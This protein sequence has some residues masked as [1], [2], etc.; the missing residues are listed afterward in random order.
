MFGRKQN[1]PQEKIPPEAQRKGALRRVLALKIGLLMFFCVVALRLIQIQVI[2]AQKYK[3]IARRQ[4]ESEVPLPA[5]RGTVQDRHG[6]VLASN[7]MFVSFAADPKMLGASAQTVARRFARAFN[8]STEHYLRLLRVPGRRFVWLERGADP[9]KEALIRPKD[10]TGLIR[11]DEPKRIYHYEHVAG[12]L[13]GF[14]DV[15]NKGLSGVELQFDDHLRGKSGNVV[16]QRDGLGRSHPSVDYPRVEPVSGKSIVLTLDL[17][18]QQIAE[19]ELKR[20]IERA[21]AESGL[22]VMLDPRTGEVLAMANN[23]SLNPNSFSSANATAMKNRVITDMFEPGSVFKIVTVSAALE[24]ELIKKGEKFF[25]EN[26]KYVVK[27]ARGNSRTITDTHEHG[28]LSFQEAV[29]VSSNIVMAKVSDRIG[30]EVLYTTARDFGFGISTGLGLS[31]EVNG[32]LKKPTQW[33]G[34][35][36]NSIAYGYEV[37]ATPLQIAAAYAA[38]ANNGVLMKPFIVGKILDEHD[39]VESETRPQVIRTVISSETAQQLT[40]LLKG[41]VERGT[42]MTAKVEGL[43]VAGKTGT[44]RKVIDGRYEPGKY[45]ASFAGF[46][47]AEDP[48]VVCVVMLDNPREGYTGALASAPIFKAIAAK[49]STTSGRFARTPDVVI[50]G[51]IPVAVPDVSN[52]KTAVATEILESHGFEVNLEGSGDV[53]YKQQPIPGTKIRRKEIVKLV[54]SDV[55]AVKKGYAVVPDLRGLTIRR[56]INKLVIHHLDVNIEGSGVV[57]MQTPK[58]GQLVKIGTKVSLRCDARRAVVASIQ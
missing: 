51:Q 35:T 39:E 36:L 38:V 33:S 15:D 2:D 50:A 11:I 55:I 49:V 31:G 42:G 18:L 10:F 43:S 44:S 17:E 40:E 3:E 27:F 23:P 32:E 25:A 58:A 5:L 6:N 12:Q 28:W 41:V 24:E 53:V 20:G 7:S 54:T 57:R 46:F 13:I 29:E 4:Y 34:T 56:A 21:K 1:T 9:G 37:G 45:T 30:A 8:K 26:G 16:M 19:E 47:P 48:Q 22:V 14:T 52:M